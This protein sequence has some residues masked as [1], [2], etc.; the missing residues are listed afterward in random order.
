MPEN[1]WSVARLFNERALDAIRLDFPAPTTHARNLYHLSAAMWDA[2][3]AYDPDAKGLFFEPEQVYRDD[4]VA[5]DD[6][7]A[8]AA[9]R[10]LRY[11]YEEAAF[12][13][14]KI[15]RAL[16]ETMRSLCLDPTI[17]DLDGDTAAARGN[18]IAQTIILETTSDGS[19]ERGNYAAQY[20]PKNAPMV[21]AESGAVLTDPDRWQPLQFEEAFTQHGQRLPSQ[22]QNYIGPHWGSVTG[23]ALEEAPDGL[24]IDPGPQPLFSDP[25]TRPEFVASAIEVIDYS[26]RLDPNSGAD[27]D[28]SPGTLGNNSLGTND[29][30]GHAVNPHTGDPYEP[31]VI[32]EGDYGRAVAEFWADGPSSETPPG[33]WNTIANAAA[34]DPSATHLIAGTRATEDRLEWNV[35]LYIALNGALHDA[36]V[37]AWGIKAHYESVRPI[38]MIRWLSGNGQ[39]SDPNLPSY[40]DDGISLVDGL[41]ELIDDASSRPGGPHELLQDHIGDVAIRAWQANAPGLPDATAGVGWIL[42]VDWLPYQRDTFVTPAFAGYV[43]GHSAFSRAG[44]E[45]LAAITGDPFFPGGISSWSIERGELDF[46]NGPSHDVVLQ[47]ATYFDAADQAGSSRLYGGIHILADDLVG[48]QIGAE[49]GRMAWTRAQQLLPS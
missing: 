48:R 8:Y 5:R 17:S 21:I 27:I 49:V 35:S 33:H 16:N 14:A 13:K 18:R 34:D 20:S 44:A 2:W 10:L 25:T 47:W 19:N 29:G 30:S 39:S 4:G 42:G 40:A 1:G 28:I 38:S 23:F 3:A 15:R 36:A 9:F 43:S 22:L 45:V 32:S 31:N 46:E 11:R 12:G 37:A 24:P 6:T 7:I 26:S 41:V